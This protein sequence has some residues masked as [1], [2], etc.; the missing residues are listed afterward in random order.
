MSFVKFLRNIALFN[1]VRRWFTP[2]RKYE[3][4]DFGFRDDTSATIFGSDIYYRSQELQNHIDALE[5]ELDDLDI[6][7]ERYDDIQER[8]DL[9]MD[10]IDEIDEAE[11]SFYDDF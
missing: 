5:D 9:L 8:I 2:T 4:V 1:M 6:M 3:R 7:S 11:D 10:R